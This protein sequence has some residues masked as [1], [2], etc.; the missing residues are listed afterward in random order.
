MAKQY[1]L[2]YF[3]FQK[4][5]INDV[6][7]FSFQRGSKTGV[8]LRCF[9]SRDKHLKIPAEHGK[10]V[11]AEIFFFQ[12]KEINDVQV[13]AYMFKKNLIHNQRLKL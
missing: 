7:V 9:A 5:E 3:F 1:R 2:K 8:S 6:P 13:Q 12:K 11:S 4:K 10:T